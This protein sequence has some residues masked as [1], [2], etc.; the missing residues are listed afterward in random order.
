[1]MARQQARA[2]ANDVDENEDLF[3]ILLCLALCYE[4][5]ALDEEMNDE[6]EHEETR[7]LFHEPPK[8]A[9][10]RSIPLPEFS[11]WQH[12]NDSGDE[13]DETWFTWVGLPKVSFLALVRPPFCCLSNSLAIFANSWD[14]STDTN[15]DVFSPNDG[16]LFPSSSNSSFV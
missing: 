16:N 6:E 8:Y 5:L 15:C 4:V 7:L 14:E 3:L 9:S 2:D 12:L 11:S 10:R 13:T 1:M